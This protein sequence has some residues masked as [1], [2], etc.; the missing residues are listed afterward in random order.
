MGFTCP[1]AR[2]WVDMSSGQESNPLPG[3]KTPNEGEDG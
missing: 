3:G 2:P 1:L